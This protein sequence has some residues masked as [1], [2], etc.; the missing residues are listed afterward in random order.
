MT[1]TEAQAPLEVSPSAPA[2]TTAVVYERYGGP[3]VLRVREIALPALEPDQVLVRV[4]ATSVN[5]AQWYGVA[6]PWFARLGGGWRAPKEQRMNSDLA[7]TVVA[8]G[9]AVARLRPGDDVFGTGM[10]AW[11]E[12][13]VASEGRLA[14]K[15]ATVS[16]EDAAALPIAGITALQALRDKAAVQAGQ[17]VLVNG[18]SGGVGTYTVQLAEWLGADVTAVCS[19]PNVELAR[20]L[21]ATRVVDYRQDDFCRLDLRHEALIDVAGSRPLRDLSKVLT[22]DGTVVIVGAKMSA[23]GLGPLGHIVGTK[24]GAIFRSQRATFFIARIN[25]A[26]LE[27]LGGLLADGTIRSVVDR[28]FAGL[29][30]IAPALAYLGESH[31]RGKI[32]VSV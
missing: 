12:H 31:A 9:T 23:R 7:G 25:T 15:P 19:T 10:G 29:D 17:R 24:L 14:L 3:D 1:T 4:R 16:F 28:R 6:G 18:A 13:A 30:G 2:T 8:V 11:G 26:D 5:P 20:S 32:V 21:G 27:L 22:P